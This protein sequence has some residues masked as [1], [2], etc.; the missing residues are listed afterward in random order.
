MR[1]DMSEEISAADLVNTA[2][3]EELTEIIR[4]Y[5]EEQWAGR[6]AQAIMR[7]RPFMTTSALAETIRG[8]VPGGA[9]HGRIDPATRSFQAIRIAV[10]RE[11]EILPLGLEQSIARLNPGGRIG[12]LSYHSLEHR[13]VR[14]IFRDHAKKGELELITDRPVTPS[15]DELERNSRSRSA[16]LRAARKKP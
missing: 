4:T 13:I 3:I 6:I 10:N 14:N 1:M 2:S 9:S 11:L 16:Q 5:G 7:R 8:A 15:Q 12:V